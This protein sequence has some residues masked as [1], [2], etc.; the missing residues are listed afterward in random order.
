MT[1]IGL[2]VVLIVIGVLLYLVNSII[3][4]DAKI[5]LIL[6]VVVVL[7]VCLW[8]LSSFGLLTGGALGTPIRIR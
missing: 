3:P 6:N 5:K 2:I 8:L 4:M 7:V 1:L